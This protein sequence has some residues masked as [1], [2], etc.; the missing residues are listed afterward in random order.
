MA[1]EN[2]NQVNIQIIQK[3]KRIA[4]DASITYGGQEP[5]ALARSSTIKKLPVPER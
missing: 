4:T 5:E 2:D 1:D 3:K